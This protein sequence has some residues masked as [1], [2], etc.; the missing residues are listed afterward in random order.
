MRGVQLADRRGHWG[1]KKWGN[2]PRFP[3]GQARK[4]DLGLP[5]IDACVDCDLTAQHNLQT[6]NVRLLNV[7]IFLNSITYSILS[8]PLHPRSSLTP[9]WLLLWEIPAIYNAI[10]NSQEC[11]LSAHENLFFVSF[12]D[13]RLNSLQEHFSSPFS[14]E[15]FTGSLSNWFFLTVPGTLNEQLEPSQAIAVKLCHAYLV[16]M[17]HPLRKPEVQSVSNFPSVFQFCH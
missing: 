16:W 10:Q 2:W 11:P 9:V 7:Q 13:F 14:P 12:S 15:V 1:S 6:L 17:A 4:G 5:P 8:V 3:R